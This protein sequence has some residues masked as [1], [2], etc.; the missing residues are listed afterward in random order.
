MTVDVVRQEQVELT[1]SDKKYS[2]TFYFLDGVMKMVRSNLSYHKT[3]E[4]WL[5]FSKAIQ[6]MLSRSKR[7]YK[8]TKKAQEEGYETCDVE[9]F[10]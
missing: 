6:E 7:F 9:D 3:R 2:I 4:E 5:F 10:F 1:V 8:N